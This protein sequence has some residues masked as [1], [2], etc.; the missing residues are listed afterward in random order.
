[1]GFPTHDVMQCLEI[2]WFAQCVLMYC[3]QAKMWMWL[4]IFP[5]FLTNTSGYHKSHITLKYKFIPN[6][7]VWYCTQSIALFAI[8]SHFKNTFQKVPKASLAPRTYFDRRTVN[9]LRTKDGAPWGGC[10]SKEGRGSCE[11]ASFEGRTQR[12]PSFLRRT[13]TV[14]RSKYV[15]GSRDAVETF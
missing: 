3:L 9:V 4:H 10:L 7:R 15:R 8:R 13:L 11:G 2:P 14:L 5:F 12:A 1:M 6:R